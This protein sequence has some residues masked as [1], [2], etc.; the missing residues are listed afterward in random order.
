MPCCDH[1]QIVFFNQNNWEQLQSERGEILHKTW[2]HLIRRRRSVF[3][4]VCFLFVRPERPA[5]TLEMEELFLPPTAYIQPG[6]PSSVTFQYFLVPASNCNYQN[7]KETWN[8]KYLP[9]SVVRRGEGLV[10]SCPAS[11]CGPGA[12]VRRGKPGLSAVWTS[13]R[14]GRRQETPGIIVSV[15]ELL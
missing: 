12:P 11:L 14:G 8:L 6:G 3:V 7:T 1:D 10:S 5:P 9:I 4:S 15:T 13:D 2:D